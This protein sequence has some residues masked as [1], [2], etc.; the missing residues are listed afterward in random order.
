MSSTANAYGQMQPEDAASEFS[1]HNFLIERRLARVRTIITVKVISC[2]NTGGLSPIG[3]V[4]VQPTTNMMD[5]AGN[6]TKH[7]VINNVPY[8]RIQ[9]GGNAVINDPQPGD[10]GICA[11]CDRDISS[12]AANSGAISNPGSW[13][14][15]DMADAVY[16]FSFAAQAPTQYVQFNADGV[17]ISDA[18]GNLIQML[19][20]GI[21]VTTLTLEVN[22]DLE[23]DTA[24]TGT[25]TSADGKTITVTKGIVTSIV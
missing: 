2:T 11:I 22:G 12:V 21:T 18:N 13:R 16:L 4:S 19:S 6:A 1:K 17:T 8:L 14:R 23:V 20:A 3:T 10:Y 9:G 15:F 5:G 7:G 25:F 24:A